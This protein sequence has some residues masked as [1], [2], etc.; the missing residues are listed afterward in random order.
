MKTATFISKSWKQWNSLTDFQIKS[1][2]T[3]VLD[4]QYK[5]QEWE[6]VITSRNQSILSYKTI[7]FKHDQNEYQHTHKIVD[8]NI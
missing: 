1:T 5:S 7:N 8:E 6:I 2:Q 3:D 4:L